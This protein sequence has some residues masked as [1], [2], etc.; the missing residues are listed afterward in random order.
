M[1]QPKLGADVK[2]YAIRCTN[3]TSPVGHVTAATMAGPALDGWTCLRLAKY[4][5]EPR[6]PLTRCVGA[7]GPALIDRSSTAAPLSLHISAHLLELSSAHGAHRF[8]LEDEEGGQARLLVR[9]R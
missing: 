6:G 2:W 8:V 7:D 1:I 9:S 3:C 4:A 5:M